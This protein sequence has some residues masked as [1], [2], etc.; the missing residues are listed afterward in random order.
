MSSRQIKIGLYLF[1]CGSQLCETRVIP[2]EIVISYYLFNTAAIYHCWGFSTNK[3]LWQ[4][5]NGCDSSYSTA[6]TIETIFGR[7]DAWH[8]RT[9]LI[10]SEVKWKWYFYLNG[11]E[12]ER[13]GGGWVRRRERENWVQWRHS[14]HSKIYCVASFTIFFLAFCMYFTFLDKDDCTAR[15]QVTTEFHSFFFGNEKYF[16]FIHSL[17]SEW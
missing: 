9:P 14:Y 7:V 3:L 6:Q 10:C 16:I 13:E 8:G 1:N 5:D 2:F 17:Q 12:C 4:Q 15:A 11:S